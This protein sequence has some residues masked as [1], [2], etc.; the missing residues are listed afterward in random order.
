MEYCDKANYFSDKI[1]DRLTP[2]GNK[3]KLLTYA[4]DIL[5][6]LDYTH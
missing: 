1:I 2:I 6:G 5:E 4:E 3:G